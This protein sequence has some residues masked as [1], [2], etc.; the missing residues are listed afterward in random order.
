MT[1]CSIETKRINLETRTVEA[2]RF[3]L[4]E[5]YMV[6]RRVCKY[7]DGTTWKDYNVTKTGDY[8]PDI[9]YNDGIFSDEK[10][11]FKIQTTAYGDKNIDEIKK[12]MAGYQEAIEAVE[13]LTKNFC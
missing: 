7:A 2:T 11:G 6:T 3:T 8:I 9:Y 4:G 12:I 10:P 13:I 1:L 5:H